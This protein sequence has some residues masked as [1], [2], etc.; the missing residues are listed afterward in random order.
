[1]REYGIGLRLRRK[2]I[3]YQIANQLNVISK[4]VRNLYSKRVCWTTLILIISRNRII[5]VKKVNF[6]IF[7]F[8]NFECSVCSFVV[9]VFIFNHKRPQ[10][11]SLEVNKGLLRHPQLF[12]YPWPFFYFNFRFYIEL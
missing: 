11:I 8:V 6:Y 10:R 4:E 5:G 3:P 9:Y 7:Y 1:V 12:V 2:P